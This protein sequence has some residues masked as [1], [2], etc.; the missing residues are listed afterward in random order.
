MSGVQSN[1]GIIPR[2]VQSLFDAIDNSSSDIEF[3][4]RDNCKYVRNSQSTND[5]W[6]L[7]IQ[8][9]VKYIEIYLEKVSK[10]NDV[11]QQPLVP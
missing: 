3:T 5:Y 8:V 2:L 6:C 10:C 11:I 9:S 1:K 4:V 7:S